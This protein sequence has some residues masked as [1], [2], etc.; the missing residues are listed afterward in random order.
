M[1]AVGAVYLV[2]VA[3]YFGAVN[4]QDYRV[5]KVEA[6]VEGLGQ[7][8]T[9]ALQLRAR[10]Q[11]LKTREVLKFAAL[12]CWKITAELLPEA[13]TLDS[14]TFSDGRK[15]ALSGTAP[16]DAVAELNKF[17]GEIR[18]AAMNGEPMFD[19]TKGQQLSSHAGIGGVVVWSFSLELKRSEGE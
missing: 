17:Y 6:T 18:K 19:Y 5:G 9:N 11:V 14:F 12:E 3:L 15:F 2:I 8:Y 16:G 13:L 1:F 7:S 10:L 4:V